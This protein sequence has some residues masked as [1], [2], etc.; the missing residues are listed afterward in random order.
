MLLFQQLQRTHKCNANT[1]KREKCIISIPFG[2]RFEN[3][4]TQMLFSLSDCI[5]LNKIFSFEFNSLGQRTLIGPEKCRKSSNHTQSVE[6]IASTQ[7]HFYYL[8]NVPKMM[9]DGNFI[10]VSFMKMKMPI[11]QCNDNKCMHAVAKINHVNQIQPQFF[12]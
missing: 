6:L 9:T 12:K 8:I 11:S 5:H 2:S 3:K 7:R 1:K 4:N 10:I